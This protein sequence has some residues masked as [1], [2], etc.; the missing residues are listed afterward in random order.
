MSTL[1]YYPMLFAHPLFKKSFSNCFNVNFFGFLLSFQTN[2][3]VEK[4][5]ARRILGFVDRIQHVRTS[6][7]RFL[8]PRKLPEA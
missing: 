1:A 7:Y 3:K 8:F 5:V 2:G 6:K 4:Y